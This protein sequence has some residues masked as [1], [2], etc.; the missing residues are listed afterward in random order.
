MNITEQNFIDVFGEGTGIRKFKSPARVNIIGEHIDYNGGLVFPFALEF[1]T[2]GIARKRNDNV[3]LLKSLL[4]DN[5]L[6]VSLD[7]LKYAEEHN[8]GNYVKGVVDEFIKAGYKVGGFE[9]LIDSNM[10]MSSGL[11][12]S[13]SLEVLVS[14]ILSEL[15]ELNV[16]GVD[17]ALISQKAENNYMGVKC[18][19]MDQ[20]IIANGKENT[21]MLLNCDTLEYKYYNLDL[22]NYKF[23]ICNTKK[24][25]NLV[26]SK[27]NER[28][29]ECMEGLATLQ[30][31]TDISCLAELTVEQFNQYKDKI[32][33]PTVAK[34]VEHVVTEMERT[35]KA[36]KAM[37]QGDLV[38]LGEYIT[39]SHNS[40]RDLYEVTG[41]E[42]DTIVELALQEE[43]VLG[44]R[45]T[46]AGF[47]GCAIALVREDV[48]EQFIKNVGKKYT[49]KV[50]LVAE[51]YTSAV[52]NGVE[53]L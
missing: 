35:T 23:V 53:E 5:V 46:G 41:I 2:F 50:G 3:I 31:Y 37:E 16:S 10:P 26:E 8:W 25:R 51:F 48:V 30:Q 33:N 7:D 43:G 39:G 13:A 14:K 36:A 40:L 32:E 22:H 18:G 15:F 4:F 12:S 24:P 9:L 45:M 29:S 6:E 49:E 44:A 27:Y 1:G 52:G 28:L 19:I 17:M 42:L 34:R 47:G 11:S 21:A 20:F 38:K